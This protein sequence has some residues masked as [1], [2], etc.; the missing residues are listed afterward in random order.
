MGVPK[1]LN[2]EKFYCYDDAIIKDAGLQNQKELSDVKKSCACFGYFCNDMLSCRSG[3]SESK[4]GSERCFG[5]SCTAVFS[6][7]GKVTFGCE[8]HRYYMTWFNKTEKR[9][10]GYFCSEKY[11]GGCICFEEYCNA[12]KPGETKTQAPAWPFVDS[13]GG[14]P[15]LRGA[16]L[17]LALIAPIFV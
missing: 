2:Y 3:T 4:E 7:I 11:P 5:R 17:V 10:D 1:K 15:S 16:V 14:K 9:E 6:K 13:A 12:L 8:Y